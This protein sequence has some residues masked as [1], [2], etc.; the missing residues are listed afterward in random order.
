MSGYLTYFNP[1][2]APKRMEE[3]R[4]TP[5]TLG[6]NAPVERPKKIH[7]GGDGVVGSY[8]ERHGHRPHP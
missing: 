4:Q 8:R 7:A 6:G 2:A 3:I 1:P 5:P